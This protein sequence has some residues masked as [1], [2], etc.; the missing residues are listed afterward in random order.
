VLPQMGG[1][2]VIDQ[3]YRILIIDDEPEM[4]DYLAELL[5]THGYTVAAA[6]TGEDGLA[7][8][9]SGSSGPL[10]PSGLDLVILDVHG[11]CSYADYFIIC[12]GTSDRQVQAIA[13]AIHEEIKKGGRVP[14]GDEGLEAGHWAL[15]DYG[16]V[17]TH[18][19]YQEDRDY[20]QL[21]RLWY[22]A[23]RISM[24]GVTD[25]KWERRHK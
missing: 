13:R 4:V 2:E 25:D 20:Y 24:K 3:S 15:I 19:F 8:M 21:E 14:L 1:Q 18:I 11:V 6:H 22:D 23:P 5:T 17:V 16:D 9:R 12:S 10:S 7:A